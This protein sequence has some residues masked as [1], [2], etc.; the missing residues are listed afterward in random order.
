MSSITK[1]QPKLAFTLFPDHV[2]FS[3][4]KAIL[5]ECGILDGMNTEQ[6]N[7]IVKGRMKNL[8]KIETMEVARRYD[9]RFGHTEY[10]VG[11]MMYVS[12]RFMKRL[13]S[14]NQITIRFT[15]CGKSSSMVYNRYI[16]IVDQGAH[17]IQQDGK[18]DCIVGYNKLANQYTSSHYSAFENLYH[19]FHCFHILHFPIEVSIRFSQEDSPKFAIATD[20]E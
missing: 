14:M 4:S 20:I 3:S 19:I 2:K 12:K 5:D 17:Y 11:L 15:I 13:E 10:Y 18:D 16:E 7:Y 9:T 8:F 6:A 1:T